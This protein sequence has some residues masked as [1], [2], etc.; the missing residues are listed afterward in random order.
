MNKPPRYVL[1]AGYGWSGSS[2]VVD[3]LREYK[4]F[5]SAEIEF[6]LVKDPKGISDLYDAL[7]EHWDPLKS[8]IALKD[9]Y[10]FANHLN[11]KRSKFSLYAGLNYQLFFG[12]TFFESTINFLHQLTL[13][14]YTGHWWYFDFL[15]TRNQMAIKKFLS[16]FRL[17][18]NEKMLF[19]HVNKD[20]FIAIVQQYI[21]SIFKPIWEKSS[22][23]TIILDQAISVNDF[24]NQMRYFKDSK[25]IIVDRDPRDIYVDLMKSGCLLGNDIR[26][27]HNVSHYIEWHKALRT[28]CSEIALHPDALV[29]SFHDLINHYEE[30]VAKI[31]RFLGLDSSY[32]IRKGKHLIVNNSKK[33]IGLWKEVLSKE[34][35]SILETE[36]AEWIIH[37]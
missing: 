21:E 5:H 29:I 36:L 7:I 2:A 11:A 10:W 15:K 31:E 34:E 3:L 12:K 6:R 35:N 1:V 25:T 37:D 33:N 16:L 9:F 19:S 18:S 30:T 26:K 32:H 4:G 14:E 17:S 23:K 13:F 22:A 8:D 27:N 28:R 20:D 24:D